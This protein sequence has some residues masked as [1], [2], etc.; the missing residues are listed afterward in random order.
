MIRRLTLIIRLR[1]N[2]LERNWCGEVEMVSPHRLAAFKHQKELWELL[3][4]W[5][6]EPAPG[7][8]LSGED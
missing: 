4:K 7:K 8:A 1:W 5:I 6:W 3:E 2:P